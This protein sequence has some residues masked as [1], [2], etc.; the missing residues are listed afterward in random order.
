VYYQRHV[1]RND[2]FIP[3]LSRGYV[4][5]QWQRILADTPKDYAYDPEP[6]FKERTVHLDGGEITVI[7]EVT[8]RPKNAKERSLLLQKDPSKNAKWLYDPACPRGCKEGAVNVSD[9][10]GDPTFSMLTHTELCECVTR[11]EHTG[12]SA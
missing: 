1:K 12:P 10:P 8:R 3:K 7:K 9:Y 5:Q 11:E 6:M 4:L 2:Y